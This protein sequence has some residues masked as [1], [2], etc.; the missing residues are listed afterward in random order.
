MNNASKQMSWPSCPKPTNAG[1]ASERKSNFDKPSERQG[2]L[3]EASGCAGLM[4][5]YAYE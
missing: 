4:L 3:S 2:R 1:E 5:R